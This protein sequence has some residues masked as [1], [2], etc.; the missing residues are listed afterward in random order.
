MDVSSPE[1]PV[2]RYPRS[3]D[4]VI[5][6]IAHL[7]AKYPAPQHSWKYGPSINPADMILGDLGECSKKKLKR[8]AEKHS[9][10][11]T[12]GR[13]KLIKRMY[14]HWRAAK[15][16]IG[17][18]Y[19]GYGPGYESTRTPDC[20]CGFRKRADIEKEEKYKEDTREARKKQRKE[21]TE[22][23]DKAFALREERR[24]H[25]RFPRLLFPRFNSKDVLQIKKWGYE[26]WKNRNTTTSG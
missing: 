21:A 25:P 4:T 5:L 8:L 23:W 6:Y 10:K 26:E 9:L 1:K 11:T 15:F 14:L 13:R 20:V 12:G 24:L 3:K 16:G 19:I 22:L 17:D 18:P 2:H 7:R